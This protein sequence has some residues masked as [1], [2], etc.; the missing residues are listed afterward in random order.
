VPKTGCKSPL[1]QLQQVRC[2]TKTIN[3]S[4]LSICREL[5]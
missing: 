4:P 2:C 3:M 5:E 1:N